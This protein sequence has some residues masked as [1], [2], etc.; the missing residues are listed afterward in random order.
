MLGLLLLLAVL[1]ITDEVGLADW[2]YLVIVAAP[3]LLL[4]K[5][6][7]WYL[8]KASAAAANDNDS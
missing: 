6:R 5:D 4:I 7:A 8:R 2:I 1:T 3:L